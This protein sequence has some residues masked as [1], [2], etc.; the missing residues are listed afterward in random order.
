ME[1]DSRGAD[2][3]GWRATAV[4]VLVALFVIYVAGTAL[5]IGFVLAHE[6]F[7]FDA[8]NVAVDTGAEPFS[9]GNFF[10]YWWQQY[11]QS[12][13][14]LGQPLTYLSYKLAYVG[15]VAMALSFLATSLAVTVLA[16]GRW[17]WRRAR[18]L[19]MWTIAIG[20]A[21]FALPEI[22]RNLFCRA[23]GANY[24]FTLAVQLWF[25][26]PLRLARDDDPGNGRCVA[27][28]L[29][30][31]AAGACN[32]HTGPTLIA[33]IAAYGWW[34]RRSGRSLRLVGAGLGG[35]TAGFALIFFAPGQNHRYE[36]LAQQISLPMRAIQRG[37]GGNLEIVTDYLTYAAPLLVLI[38]VVLIASLLGPAPSDERTQRRATALRLI[39]LAVA[40]GTMVS[41]TL[42]VSPKLGSRFFLV[43]TALLLAGFLALLDAVVARGRWLA[44]FVALA[45]AASGYAA[46]RTVLL[47]YKVSAQAELRMA[48][49]AAT[50]PGS[51]YVADAWSQV[52]EDWWFIGDD[53]RDLRK[54][55]LVATYFGL[56]RVYFRGYERTAP[57]GMHGIRI[58]PRYWT[59]GSACPVE[60]SG[61]DFGATKGFDFAGLH[62]GAL[63]SLE[64]LR[65]QLA[66]VEVERFQL[67]IDFVGAR[68]E[69]PRETLLLSRWQHGALEGYGGRI[70]RAPGG[71]VRT[72]HPPRELAGKPFEIYVTQVGGRVVRLGTTDGAPLEYTPWRKG[73]YWALACDATACWVFAA[74]RA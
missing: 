58:V 48:E 70:T 63:A 2:A 39:V 45:I 17:P 56:Q 28:A 31:V 24:V 72:V 38:V 32:E 16:L 33:L 36:D 15:E 11:T 14:R 67:E 71:R 27:Y 49:L 1:R 10:E 65:A 29:L 73:V 30:G 46:L 44:P 43:P 42:F 60:D 21:W 8:W 19:A 20:F 54:R 51:I 68:P 13:P 61:F 66:P 57:L 62:R 53:F 34:R 7:S 59:K 50:A 69:L 47:F 22:G 3:T 74:G 9:V 23:Y 40:V 6:P 35:F 55:E 26:V 37:I 64:V 18:D 12:N 5:H 25:L 52:D 4:R 41:V